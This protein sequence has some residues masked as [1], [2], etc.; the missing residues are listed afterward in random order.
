MRSAKKTTV[1]IEPIDLEG[2]RQG[3]SKATKAVEQ[4]AEALDKAA[5]ASEEEGGRQTTN[6][7]NCAAPTDPRAKE[8]P[9]CGTPYL[10]ASASSAEPDGMFTPS[11][12]LE[13]GHIVSSTGLLTPNEVRRM[14]GLGVM[15][16]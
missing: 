5:E 16:T 14:L 11:Y 10:W 7:P 2:M 15:K 3:I 12:Y 4:L 8:C 9:Y 13:A 6:C 1:K